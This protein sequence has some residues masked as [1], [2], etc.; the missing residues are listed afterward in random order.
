MQNKEK[1][2]EVLN[3]GK[4]IKWKLMIWGVVFVALAVVIYFIYSKGYDKAEQKYQEEI[5]RLEEEN[6]RLSEPIA[7]YEEASK[8][9]DISLINTTIQNIGELATI[10]YL[11]TDAGK[12]SDPKQLW[13]RDIPLTTKSFIA[14]WDGVI[15]AG[16][17]ITKITV[18]VNDSEKKLVVNIPK[19][20]IL[21]HEIDESSFETLDEK[22]G[23]FNAI[24]IDDIREFDAV[25]KESMENRA[26]ENGILEKAF[27]N[28]KYI[29]YEL[30]NIDVV[31]EQGYSIIFEVIEE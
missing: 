8:E 22:D 2:D 15:K 21:S 11:Y 20:Q 9:V 6:E 19:A 4:Q 16:V 23:L 12:Y 24:K 26:I 30:I 7:V 1:I 14:K 25:S 28:A 31:K 13:G 10:E 5:T 18:E 17:D 3:T 29:I 27:E